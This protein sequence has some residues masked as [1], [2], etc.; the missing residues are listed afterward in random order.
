MAGS[1]LEFVK[2][3]ESLPNVRTMSAQDV[4]REAQ[5]FGRRTVDGSLSFSSNVRNRSAKV[6]VVIGS[7]RVR[8]HSLNE[9]QSG[10]LENLDATLKTVKEYLK[11]APLICVKRTIGANGTFNPQ[12]TLYL[13]TQRSDNIRQA[14]LWAN[15][16]RDY[17]STVPGPE[18]YLVCIPE[19]QE[20]QR[21]I[22]CFP[23][24][25]LTLAL[26]S[27]YV[28]EVKMGFLR[29]AMWKAKEQGMLSLHAGSKMVHAR[30]VDGRLKRYGV[31]FFGLSGT[32]KSTHSCH[33]HGILDTGEG[34]QILQ[35]DIVFLGKDGSAL[36]TEQ[37][38]YLKTEG[39]TEEYQPVIYRA[40]HNGKALL[41]NVMVDSE[42]RIALANL[43]LGGNGRAIIPREAMHPYIAESINLPPLRELD[44]LMIF[45][46]TRRMTVLP[47]ASKLNAEQ[48]VAA[49][50]L[51]E[52]I[53]TSAGDPLRVGQSVRVVGTN[54]FLIG[55]PTQ[56]GNWFYDFLKESQ[57]KVQCFLLNTG[58]VGEIVERNE[59]GKPLVKQ[60]VLRV[61]ISEMA[62]IIRSILK[63]TIKWEPEPYFGTLVPTKVDGLDISKFS[64]DR[65][66][67]QEQAEA[68]ARTLKEEREKWLSQFKGMPSQT[69]KALS[70]I[71]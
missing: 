19:W 43:T 69:A 38:F 54:P 50:M 34:I 64:L 26:G 32:G 3:L 17:V 23:D 35:D 37:G 51:G 71:S 15:T 40:L 7:D 67:T 29:M 57:D 41:E 24:E 61:T 60:P 16:L 1:L 30:Q 4:E 13:S 10:I 42:G 39:L 46:I 47:P 33:D 49:F 55:D 66:Y 31:L 12:C 2:G 52:S 25:G 6:S 48:A 22:L 63:G 44:G 68:Y 56:E 27:D 58:G 70:P 14:Y 28:G 8:D 65:F 18:L 62:A 20:S 36:G 53:E 11:I 9:Q 5:V 45:F 59:Q 21:Q